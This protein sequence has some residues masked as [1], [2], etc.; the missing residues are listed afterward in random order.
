VSQKA[1]DSFSHGWGTA[2]IVEMLQTLLGVTLTSPGAATVRIQPPS[3]GLTHAAGT[4]WTERGPVSVSWTSTPAGQSVN[5]DVPVNV[6]AVVVLDGH[7]Y[8]VGSGH[9]HLDS[10]GK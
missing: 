3:G 6:T 9:T 7:S 10:I 4:Q 5:V 1:N 2:G 8:H